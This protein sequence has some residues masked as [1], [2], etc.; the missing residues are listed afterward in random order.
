MT[1]RRGFFGP[2]KRKSISKG[3]S[4]N[5]Q[6]VK[7][8]INRRKSKQDSNKDASNGRFVKSET[9][10]TELNNSVEIENIQIDAEQNI[11]IEQKN[12]TTEQEYQISPTDDTYKN[13]QNKA[14]GSNDVTNSSATTDQVGEK[15]DS[16]KLQ[17]GA[18]SKMAGVVAL[19]KK[20]K[21]GISKTRVA[22]KT[23][24]ASE[25][26]KEKK[27]NVSIESEATADRTLD[28][29][30]EHEISD[31]I[32]NTESEMDE[33]SVNIPPT[34]SVSP[35]K[36]EK[37]SQDEPKITD[38]DSLKPERGRRKE[39]LTSQEIMDRNKKVL[40]EKKNALKIAQDTKKES[41][42]EELSVPVKKS[43]PKN[44]TK[45]ELLSPVNVTDILEKV[46]NKSKLGSSIDPV[47]TSKVNSL[48]KRGDF[49][50]DRI[51]SNSL[52]EELDD[53]TGPSVL[54]EGAETSDLQSTPTGHTSSHGSDMNSEV[55]STLQKESP[56]SEKVTKVPDYVKNYLEIVEK[57]DE[58]TE[59]KNLSEIQR[60][61]LLM[62]ILDYR[63]DSRMNALFEL[64]GSH[65][66]DRSK[67]WH[68]ICE[69]MDF[70][71]DTIKRYFSTF[72]AVLDEK[73]KRS[74]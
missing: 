53:I 7:R 22:R 70:P 37:K 68:Q 45:K 32:D 17:E 73:Q 51:E 6:P 21:K 66:N 43:S 71:Y 40:E 14:S 72:K 2:K 3:Q 48:S 29:Q 28:N 47:D 62:R 46:G 24:S 44:Q 65:S 10:Q 26:D 38:K 8:Q 31:K 61:A 4:K 23:S 55:N 63:Y 74:R 56:G 5:V 33:N 52:S 69:K 19:P 41:S 67:L 49:A 1:K 13:A 15:G 18:K 59:P 35:S 30:K 20:K 12:E 39:R 57:I 36:M 58:R 54:M 42:Q 34:E 25:L 60:R 50:L 9:T 27:E 11:P 64:A 16:D